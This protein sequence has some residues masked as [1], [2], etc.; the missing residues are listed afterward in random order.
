MR[1]LIQN[2]KS[3]EFLADDAGWVSAIEGA[4][5]LPLTTLV[6]DFAGDF[7]LGRVQVV[8][9]F[10]DSAEKTGSVQSVGQRH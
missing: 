3:G 5:D 7:A 1:I 10:P 9:H 4:H 2:V 6:H 8:L